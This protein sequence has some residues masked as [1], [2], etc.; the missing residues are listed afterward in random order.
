MLLG[1]S[2]HHPFPPF[3]RVLALSEETR[4]HGAKLKPGDIPVEEEDRKTA[5]YEDPN[6][7]SEAKVRVKADD[8]PDVDEDEL[9]LEEGAVNHDDEDFVLSDGEDDTKPKAARSAQPQ[10]QVRCRHHWLL[11]AC[12]LNWPAAGAAAPAL[13][14]VKQSA[15][16]VKGTNQ[17]CYLDCRC[18]ALSSAASAQARKT[19]AAA[20]AGPSSPAQR[21]PAARRTPRP[22]R[23]RRRSSSSR[24]C[25]AR[26][27]TRSGQVAAAAAA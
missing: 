20:S 3:H 19:A 17:V 15:C 22:R 12:W 16:A 23:W 10:K 2:R 24:C 1:F 18:T 5:E 4:P 14:C 13:L 7:P 9:G 8:D 25:S 11:C 27:C 21:P 6:A 26:S